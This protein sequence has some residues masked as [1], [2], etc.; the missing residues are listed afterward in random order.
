MLSYR[1]RQELMVRR[2]E[3]DLSEHLELLVHL[4]HRV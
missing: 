3:R 2:V 1:V 4:D